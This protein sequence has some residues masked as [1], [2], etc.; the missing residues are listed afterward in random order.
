MFRFVTFVLP[1]FPS[2]SRAAALAPFRHRER[3]L[4][5]TKLLRLSIC[6]ETLLSPVFRGHVFINDC[7]SLLSVS[8]STT[9]FPG[10]SN[11]AP[12]GC[13][14]AATGAQQSNENEKC[15]IV[16]SPI[17]GK[18]MRLNNVQLLIT[19]RLDYTSCV[20]N[21]NVHL[22]M[23]SVCCLVVETK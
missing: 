20:H 9:F 11:A 10:K 17:D 19:K 3:A 13:N 8:L 21:V 2:L 5:E 6:S 14:L 18:T 15:C 7:P 12:S 22:D 16:Y 4:S 23:S 1:L